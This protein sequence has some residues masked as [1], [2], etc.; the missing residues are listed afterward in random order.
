MPMAATRVD[1]VRTRTTA[2]RNSARLRARL[3]V[4]CERAIK[5]VIIESE[6]RNFAGQIGIR[7]GNRKRSQGS[8][9][10]E[11]RHEKD[12]DAAKVRRQHRDR[13]QEGA[14]FELC[15]GFV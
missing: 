12:K 8:R 6:D 11:S 9:S 15:S 5:V 3:P 4:A 2:A 14:A 7:P 1:W 10:E 13:V